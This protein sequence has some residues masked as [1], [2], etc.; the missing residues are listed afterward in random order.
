MAAKMLGMGHA[1]VFFYENIEGGHA[2]AAN[3]KQAA[4]MF[5]L[6]YAFLRKNL[7]PS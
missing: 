3:N 7:F 5:A 1:N 2:G 6:V 4:R